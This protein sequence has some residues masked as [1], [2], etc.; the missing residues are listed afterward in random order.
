MGGHPF[1]PLFVDLADK[2]VVVIGAGRVAA[3]RVCELSQFGPSIAVVAPE[4]H[5]D[6][7]AL[8][9]TGRVTLERRAYR[10]SDL[11]GADMALAATGDAALNAE[12]GEACRR[13]GIPVNISSDRALCDF[14]FPGIAKRENIVVGVTAS[15]EDH[16]RAR[17]LTEEIRSLLDGQ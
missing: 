14:L 8:V 3:R 13:R 7:A 5:A 4:A 6:I 9:A 1:F 17:A 10:E 12:I 11:N 15:G 2:R 16:R